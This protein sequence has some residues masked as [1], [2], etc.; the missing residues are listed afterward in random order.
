VVPVNPI[1]LEEAFDLV[2]QK[3]LERA[4]QAS[5]N[6][7]DRFMLD[8]AKVVKEEK[9]TF[10]PKKIET[11]VEEI[12]DEV[13]EEEIE[14]YPPVF[15]EEAMSKL[16]N[17]LQ[18][19]RVEAQYKLQE[20]AKQQELIL[21]EELIVEETEPPKPLLATSLEG[22]LA[23]LAEALQKNNQPEEEEE[24]ETEEDVPSLEPTAEKKPYI[25]DS[26]QDN[27]YVSELIKATKNAPKMVKGSRKKADI[28]KLIAEQLHSELESFRKQ[29]FS[30][31]LMM[32]GGGG[33]TNAVQYAAGGIMRGDLN[34]TGKILSGGVDM[35]ES[36]VNTVNDII[37]ELP[38]P[39]VL[40]GGFF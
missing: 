10:V 16:T 40:G 15:V 28:K 21:E 36:I 13:F 2:R 22:V 29:L 1:S 30:S 23:R 24:E 18:K 35:T 8:L 20:E 3:P 11:V 12:V 5:S 6:P 25:P 19:A 38:L 7:F 4:V 14:H 39:T 17:A 27:P 31:N 32:G 9:K 34:V 37:V 26:K 33:G